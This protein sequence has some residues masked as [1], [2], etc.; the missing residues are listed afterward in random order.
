MRLLT[1]ARK[2]LPFGKKQPCYR[3][4]ILKRDVLLYLQKTYKYFLISFNVF[5]KYKKVFYFEPP[6]FIN[7]NSNTYDHRNLSDRF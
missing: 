4:N 1:S 2:Q 7:I 5:N 3:E 6:I